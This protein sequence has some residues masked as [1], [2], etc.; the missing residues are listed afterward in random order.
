MQLIV[1][2]SRYLPLGQT[3]VVPDIIR[4]FLQLVQVVLMEHVLQTGMQ[5]VHEPPERMYPDM[6]PVQVKAS[7]QVVQVGG[8]LAHETVTGS[9]N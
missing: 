5:F 4:L 1:P 8:Q 3:Q 6:H 7:M 2:G 9:G